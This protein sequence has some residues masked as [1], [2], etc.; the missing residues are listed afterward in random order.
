MR[1][2]RARPRRDSELT[3]RANPSTIPGRMFWIG[4]GELTFSNFE[5]YEH[6]DPKNGDTSVQDVLMHSERGTL[7]R[8]RMVEPVE[9]L[10]ARWGKNGLMLCKPLEGSYSKCSILVVTAVR[11]HYEVQSSIRIV[12]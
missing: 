10:W 5:G 12:W 1:L 8:V 4:S 11:V 6:Q 3:I 9:R 7:P 2:V